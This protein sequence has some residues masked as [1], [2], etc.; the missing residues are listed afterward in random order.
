MNSLRCF[1]LFLLVLLGATTGCDRPLRTSWAYRD[2]TPDIDPW[3]RA[4]DDEGTKLELIHFLRRK[5][6]VVYKI[7]LV[8]VDITRAGLC[9][10]GRRLLVEIN[11]EQVPTARALGFRFD[12]AGVQL[13]G[14]SASSL[15]GW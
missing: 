9:R 15:A 4:D 12:E 10:E 3:P 7:D 1:T 6:I 8:P 5:G 2:L 14:A 11:H 13:A